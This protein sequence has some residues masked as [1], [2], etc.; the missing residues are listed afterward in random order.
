MYSNKEANKKSI[1]SK[2]EK[3]NFC[4]PVS[5]VYFI[6]KCCHKRDNKLFE[7]KLKVFLLSCIP[8]YK[9]PLIVFKVYKSKYLGKV[10]S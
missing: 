4:V 9:P 2:Y 6:K 8:Y 5:K 3:K 7:N 10:A 1:K